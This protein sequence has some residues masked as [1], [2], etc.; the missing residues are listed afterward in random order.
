MGWF[1]GL[2][3]HLLINQYGEILNFRITSANVADNDTKLLFQLTQELYGW[4]FG[5]KG[6][7]LNS[8]KRVFLE[9]DGAIRFF[10]KVRKNMK[11]QDIPFEA[12]SWLGKRPIIETVIGLTKS[13]CDVAHSR[14]RSAANAFGNIL[15]GLVA[16][17]YSQ[18]KP[19]ASINLEKRL[20]QEPKAV[21]MK[22]KEQQAA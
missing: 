22:L 10:T 18:R 12:Q 4:I 21:Y 19:I 2:K 15:V 11:K 17:S 14:H 13:Q 5:D 16:Y 3:Y 8:D 9:R 20:L 6:Y 1:F 7:L